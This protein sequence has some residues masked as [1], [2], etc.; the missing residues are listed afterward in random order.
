MKHHFWPTG[1]KNVVS[2]VHPASQCLS[3]VCA[4]VLHGKNIGHY[5]QT[6]QPNSFIPAMFVG[7]IDSCHFISLSMTL[8]LAG[9]HKVSTKQNLFASFSGTLLNWMGWNLRRWSNSSWYPKTNFGSAFSNQG[10]WLLFFWL[11]KKTKC[12]DCSQTLNE[13]VLFKLGV[14]I[15]TTEHYIL[16][17]VSVALPSPPPAHTHTCMHACIPL[18]RLE[19]T[20]AQTM[21]HVK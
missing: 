5:G 12:L 10:K 2:H 8:T 14:M 6:C 19:Q 4:S 18:W 9:G 3:G 1:V 16:I 13:L 20:L 11:H 17:Y 21:I 7:T 15:D